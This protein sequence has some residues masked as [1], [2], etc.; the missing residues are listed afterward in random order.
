MRM[1]SLFDALRLLLR[2]PFFVGTVLRIPPVVLKPHLLFIGV[3]TIGY[4]SNPIC[5]DFKNNPMFF[6]STK[7]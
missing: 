2:L 6:P 3:D 1:T 4:K 7:S 5:I